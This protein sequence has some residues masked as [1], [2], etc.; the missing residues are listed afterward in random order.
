MAMISR[1]CL[2]YQQY[3]VWP[4]PQD[5]PPA[6][7]VQHCERLAGGRVMPSGG[8]DHAAMAAMKNGSAE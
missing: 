3:Q 7:L 4:P 8:A 2:A 1:M 6:W 5:P